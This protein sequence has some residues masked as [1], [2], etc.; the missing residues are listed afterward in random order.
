M[1]HQVLGRM[2]PQTPELVVGPQP[3]TQPS[4]HLDSQCCIPAP[5]EPGLAPPGPSPQDWST[6]KLRAI[7]YA[8][9]A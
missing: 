1:S 8:L 9:L 4:Q 3:V 7:V 6:A 2:M 5:V